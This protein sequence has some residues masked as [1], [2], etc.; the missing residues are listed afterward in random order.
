MVHSI[1][2]KGAV[3]YMTT[4]LQAV[5]GCVI[6]VIIIQLPVIQTRLTCCVE[7][8]NVAPRGILGEYRVSISL[9]R[10]ML[11]LYWEGFYAVLGMCG[12]KC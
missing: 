7:M 8:Q 9:R 5:I 6:A 4:I 12:L 10:K 2:I 3:L 11:S 1:E